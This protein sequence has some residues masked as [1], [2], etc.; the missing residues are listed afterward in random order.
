MTSILFLFLVSSY[1]VDRL[2][3]LNEM[4]ARLEQGSLETRVDLIHVGSLVVHQKMSGAGYTEQDLANVNLLLLTDLHPIGPKLLQAVAYYSDDFIASQ[5]RISLFLKNFPKDKE[6]SKRASE[7]NASVFYLKYIENPGAEI[8][9]HIAQKIAELIFE[10]ALKFKNNY[11]QIEDFY[12]KTLGE[13]FRDCSTEVRSQIYSRL[14]NPKMNDGFNHLVKG[15][16]E[17]KLENLPI[18]I[19]SAVFGAPLL[20]STFALA[21]KFEPLPYLIFP[22]DP[23]YAGVALTL[24]VAFFGYP[25]YAAYRVEAR[26]QKVAPLINQLFDTC[27]S[28]LLAKPMNDLQDL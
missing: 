8:Y 14:V 20:V 27:R 19:F 9:D 26:L 3:P 21:E 12:I 7:I 23:V 4:K 13:I 18:A 15:M 25:K 22:N 17:K 6:F 1:A 10:A 16:I 28:L 11:E 5:K 24:F 2:P